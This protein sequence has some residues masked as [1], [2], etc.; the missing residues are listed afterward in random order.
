[1]AVDPLEIDSA[2]DLLVRR[3]LKHRRDIATCAGWAHQPRLQ[4]R[5]VQLLSGGSN[6]DALGEDIDEFGDYVRC[7]MR[8]RQ[9]LGVKMTQ[10]EAALT[11]YVD[12]DTLD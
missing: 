10:F 7:V 12:V 2:K 3:R 4:P 1:M 8:R 5:E 6:R 9:E 11:E